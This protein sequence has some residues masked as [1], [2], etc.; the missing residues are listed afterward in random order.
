MSGQWAA[1]RQRVDGDSELALERI[2][3]DD[4][5]ESDDDLERL[6]DAHGTDEGFVVGVRFLPNVELAIESLMTRGTR[7]RCVRRVALAGNIVPWFI[8]NSLC[9]FATAK[10]DGAASA[11]GGTP[12]FFSG[13]PCG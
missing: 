7:L 11:C 2:G 8:V 4:V 6:C 12:R 1:L 10:P 9:I 13:S 5:L 3:S